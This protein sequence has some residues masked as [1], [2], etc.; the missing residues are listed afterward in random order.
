MD[1]TRFAPSTCLALSFLCLAASLPAQQITRSQL[2]ESQVA[3]LNGELSAPA[4][5]ANP[6]RLRLLLGQRAALLS[7]LIALN[8]ARALA[9]SLPQ[10]VSERLR[11]NAPGGTLEEQG[12]W[13]GTAEAIVADGVEFRSSVTRWYLRTPQ[14]ERLEMYFAGEAPT[15]PNVAVTVRGMRSANRVAVAETAIVASP[16][17]LQCSTKGVQNIAVLMVTRPSV[18]A[19]PSGFT[20]PYFQ[21]LFFGPSTGSLTTDSVNSYWQEASYGQTSAA[22]QVFGPI[23]L[24]QDY[25]CDHLGDM[26]TAVLNAASSTVD[27]TRFT[28]VALMFPVQDCTLSGFGGLGG[29]GTIGCTTV[30]VPSQGDVTL[31]TVWLPIYTYQ[32]TWDYVG[33]SAHELGHNLGLNHDSTEDYGAVPLGALSDAG[34]LVEYG[35]AYSVMGGT[36]GQSNGQPILGQYAAEHKHI[37]NWLA[38]G[39][40]QEVT[41]TGVFSL[42]PYEAQSG[43]RALRVLRDQ[44]SGAWLWVEYRQPIGDVDTSLGLIG[45]PNGEPANVFNGALIH[46]ENPNLDALHMYLLDFNPV[47]TPNQYYNAALEPGQSWQD[48]YSPL[49]L[50]VTGATSS[51]LSIS[52]SYTPSCSSIQLLSAFIPAAGGNG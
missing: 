13:Q 48:P 20:A 52:V 27:F 19:F 23:A 22:G 40:Y 1:S 49:S 25:D 36:W 15:T 2:R 12:E 51:A 6:T 31:S 39:D 38:P 45:G 4:A 35:S 41:S 28:R 10:E 3:A 18:T 11:P 29:L 44:A 37:L 9:L 8:P 43:L 34:T 24:A 32:E 46:Y 14:R 50:T 42:L 47:S 33:V 5:A 16:D 21:Q 26:E 30:A 7:D 17:G